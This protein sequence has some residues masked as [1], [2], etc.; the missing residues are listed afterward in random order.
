M[1]FNFFSYKIITLILVLFLN[2]CASIPSHVIVAPDIMFTP[3]I[4][5][6]NKQTQLDVIDMRT[7]NHI[8]QIMREGEAATLISAQEELEDTIK[9]N[10]GK[11]WQKQDLVINGSAINMIKLSIEKAVI[12]V[13]Q[14]TME[15]KVQTEIVLKVTVKNGVQTLTSTFKNSGNSDG[16][17]QADI[18][19][20][21]RNFNQ[22]LATLLQQIL[23]NKKISNFL[24]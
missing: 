5:H 1:K 24:K 4:S 18:A 9:N 8:I 10:L 15:Y 11:H 21:E 6:N 12:S 20:L 3:S 16:P 7:A 19:V 17:F 22:R 23:V 13:S 14:E 2:G